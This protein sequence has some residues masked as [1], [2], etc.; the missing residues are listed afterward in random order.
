MIAAPLFLFLAQSSASERMRLVGL[1][2]LIA[3]TPAAHAQ[4]LVEFG[5]AIPEADLL[6]LAGQP[7]LAYRLLEEHLATDA[8]DYDALW[9]AARAAVGRGLEEEESRSQNRWLDPGIDYA[10]RAVLTHPGGIDGLYWRGVAAGR[11]ALNAGPS[12]AVELA[13]LAYDDA[14]AI[15]AA[16][17]LHGG[18]HNMLGKLS[19]EVMSLSRFQRALARIFMRTTALS[20]TSWENA[21]HHLLMAAE[22]WPDHVLFHFDLGQLYRKRGRHEEARRSFLMAIGLPALHPVDRSLQ[23]RARL[24]LDELGS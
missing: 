15:L 9:R 18:A 12:Y 22:L 16:D 10:E 24:L 5:G 19:Y 7:E 4:Q 13:Q 2:F 20:D 6:Y 8:T 21:E 14:H 17:S 23:V 1:L 3:T 11:R